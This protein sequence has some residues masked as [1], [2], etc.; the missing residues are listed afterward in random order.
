MAQLER[1]RLQERWNKMA[2]IPNVQSTNQLPGPQ[3]PSRTQPVPFTDQVASAPVQYGA[4]VLYGAPSPIVNGCG[5]LVAQRVGNGS[6]FGGLCYG[7][8]SG[9]AGTLVMV[10]RVGMDPYGGTRN[11]DPRVLVGTVFEASKELSSMPKM[12]SGPQ[13]CDV[14]SKVLGLV[15]ST[16]FLVFL[17]VSRENVGNGGENKYFE[18][19]AF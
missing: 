11:P 18:S 13:C 6:G 16:T 15:F 2:G 14:C 3:R 4:P 8:S 19:C 7:G 1:L 10:D 5:G 17:F 9:T 12:Y